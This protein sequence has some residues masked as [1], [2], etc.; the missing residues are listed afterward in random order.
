LV[1]LC[2]T[3]SLARADF[4]IQSF[5]AA[6]LN[7]E[8]QVEERAGAHPYEFKVHVGM[9]LHQGGEEAPEGTLRTVV[10]DL[11]P[12]MVG[13]PLAVPRC[14]RAEFEGVHP[15]C[16]ANTQVGFAR[17]KV[18]TFGEETV[19]SPVWNLVPPVGSPVSLGVSLDNING[20]LEASLRTGEDY[21]ATVSDLT[22]PTGVPIQ[23]VDV[24]IWGVPS[25]QSHNP[26]RWCR[27]GIVLIEGGCK[28]ESRSLPFLTLPTSCTG[29]LKTTVHVESLQQPGL[30]I[31]K[32]VESTDQE[33]EPAGLRDCEAPPFSPAVVVQPQSATTD[34]PTGLHVNFHIP[35][36]EDP[37]GVAT[38]NLRDTDLT[39]PAGLTV[40]PSAASGLAACTPAQVGLDQPGPAACPAAS[41]VGA[42][43][44][45]TPLVD[46]PLA[47]TVYLAAQGAN[48]FGSLL[49]L[50]IA[51]E[52]PLT[53]VIVKQA[54]ELRPDPQTGQLRAATAE[55]P[56]LPFEDLE[57]DFSGGPRAPL[58]TPLSCGSF[59]ATASLAPWSR[60]DSPVNR[61]SSFQISSAA[62]GEPCPASAAAAPT[63]LSF[64]A[65]TVSP[66]AGSYSPLVAKF[67]R[68]NG[69]QPLAALNL[70]LPP[71]LT[72]R[73]AGMQEC[74]AA[75]LA[76]AEARSGLGEGAL[77]QK[78]PSC[79]PGSEVGIVNVGAGSGS[80]YYVQGHVYLAGPYRGAP[81]SLVI[82]T[83]A[84]AGPFDLGTVV[85]RAAL[86]VDEATA[87]GTVRSDPIPSTL[88]GIPL[89]VRSVAVDASR[90]RF[91]LNPT[92]CDPMA[93][94]AQALTPFAV[95]ALSQR[96]QVGACTALPYA[97]KLALRFKGP[98]KRTAHPRVIA[99]LTTKPGEA[100]TSFAQ[101]KLPR[102]AFLDNAHIGNVCTRVQFAA[103]A[104]NGAECPADSVY[105]R[106]AA[107]TPLLDHPLTGNVY[108]RTN[109][110]HKL[111]D[112]LLAFS[113]PPNQPI[114]F[115]LAG[116]TDS[117]KGAL[118]N[119]FE[120]A[121]DVPVSKFRLELFG[122]KK[123]LVILSS[124]LCANHNASL[125][126]RA[127]NGKEY[128][129]HPKVVAS[130]PDHS[131][132]KAGHRG[133][134]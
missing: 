53:G 54:V 133:S 33:G 45:R 112:L 21:G 87:Q 110:A 70:T 85:V 77:E 122:G 44:V 23:A 88:F 79:P 41:K 129:A 50:Y 73:F 86:Y 74:T 6:P 131:G 46:H 130:C 72:A 106:A 126:F 127:H 92:S 111:P 75:Q 64:Q 17:L 78:S 119:T 29:P 16:P 68:A 66:I 114:K 10:V 95:A 40:N 5:S 83:P 121:P 52:D 13:N 125:K 57:F 42:V 90:E 32:S 113:G 15:D 14:T 27:E 31:S 11:P 63:A 25:D 80:P 3:P 91:T 26:E 58:T 103:G 65:G 89:Q 116:K 43:T 8:G 104:G 67:S 30:V 22:I 98:A 76:R 2:L 99:T 105:G 120:Y 55:L 56:Q 94:A 100:N 118:R 38:S 35:Q 51:V 123:G 115:V 37:Q 109:P 82:V 20:F 128:T 61:T 93:I 18:S 7:R 28:S 124:G 81:L 117:V 108:L 49:A 60:P 39:L 34:S 12:G 36:S 9:N 4:G 107:T 102:A 19:V 84:L 134:K 48:P 96:F 62:A 47:G 69:S 59:T 24:S 1:A 101:V 97:P 132:S 71:G